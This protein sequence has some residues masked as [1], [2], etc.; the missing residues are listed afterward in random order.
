MRQGPTMGHY[1]RLEEPN[2]WY[3]ISNR[4]HRGEFVFRPDE[5]CRRIIKGCL[6]REVERKNVRLAAYIF[7][8]N[9]FHLVAGFPEANRA[10]FMRDFQ[11]ELSRR[12]TDRLQRMAQPQTP[13][14]AAAQTEAMVEYTVDLCVPTDI[15]GDD[16]AERR[17]TIR[18][19]YSD[20]RLPTTVDCFPLPLRLPMTDD[21]RP[22]PAATPIADDR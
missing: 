11:G 18:R 19:A 12:I 16:E 20:V 21:R 6:A 2:R 4:T 13:P 7:P 15:P 10:A 3:I 22:F 5:E 1:G 14:R 9:H 8:S 17:Q